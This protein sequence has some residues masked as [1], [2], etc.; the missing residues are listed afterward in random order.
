LLLELI[1]AVNCIAL[2]KIYMKYAVS[3]RHAGNA[4]E[5]T[6]SKMLYYLVCTISLTKTT[7][8]F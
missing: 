1:I 4:S 5:R 2:T 8:A 6:A 3:K 7:R